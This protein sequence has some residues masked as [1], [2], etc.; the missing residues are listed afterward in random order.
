LKYP[1]PQP[2]FL[3][4]PA[5]RKKTFKNRL[6]ALKGKGVALSHG[7][8]D[9]DILRLQLYFIY[10][11]R[12]LRD[13]PED[14]WTTKARAVLE[15]HFDVHEF[16]GDWCK[17]KAET[18]AEKETSNK[19]Y[20]CKTKHE[21]LYNK[22]FAALEPFITLDRLRELSHG[23]DT[24]VNESL[25]Q[26]ISWF[27]PKNKTYC[28]SDSLRNRVGMALSI[29]LVGYDAFYLALYDALGLEVDELVHHCLL[30][31]QSAR[32]RHLDSTQ[33][34]TYKNKRRESVYLK[35]REYYAK[36]KSDNATNRAYRTGSAIETESPDDS[37]DA[38]TSTTIVR[39]GRC[40]RV[41][42]KTANSKLCEFFRKRNMKS[43]N[44]TSQTSETQDTCDIQ[45]EENIDGVNTVSLCEEISLIDSITITTDERIAE[46]ASE[47]AREIDEIT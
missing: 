19:A 9:G 8:E 29:H 27:A 3:A 15:H 33:T 26:T 31:K 42:H 1:V 38:E 39:C 24:N 18:A 5:H 4:D 40:K 45:N 20:R 11:V 47:I 46:L 22:L 14:E 41:G 25:N 23:S 13:L 12:Q 21:Q 35:L 30:L 32:Q 43:C 34:T 6:Y 37:I 44:G 2:T 7:M 28:G 16:C 36:L 10:F 17:R